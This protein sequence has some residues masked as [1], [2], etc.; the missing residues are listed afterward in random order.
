MRTLGHGIPRKYPLGDPLE[1]PETQWL[2][3]LHG[4]NPIKWDEAVH[5]LMAENPNPKI[6]SEHQESVM[7]R[8]P[9]EPSLLVEDP[10]NFPLR[11]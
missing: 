10:P 11:R 1:A 7:R 6:F 5:D 3:G 2:L 4:A 9:F 8:V